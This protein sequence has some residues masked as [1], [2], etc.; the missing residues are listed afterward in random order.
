VIGRRYGYVH[1]S[2]IQLMN[3]NTRVD[4]NGMPVPQKDGVKMRLLFDVKIK[5]LS[6]VQKHGVEHTYFEM[7]ILGMT[8]HKDGENSKSPSQEQMDDL[9]NKMPSETEYLKGMEG[10]FYYLQTCEM[11]ITKVFHP[12]SES[13]SVVNLKKGIASAFSHVLRP[14]STSE[15]PVPYEA[16]V[17]TSTGLSKKRVIN[18]IPE[19]SYGTALFHTTSAFIQN[20]SA[21]VGGVEVSASS[22]T[23]GVKHVEVSEVSTNNGKIQNVQIRAAGG[24]AGRSGLPIPIICKSGRLIIRQCWNE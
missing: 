16:L 17:T 22:G 5:A 9:D 6:Q 2:I 19:D 12:E 20:I 14:H 3:Q 10:H 4:E 15:N 18:S 11:E 8:I 13:T 21:P 23:G 24:A 7:E 1:E